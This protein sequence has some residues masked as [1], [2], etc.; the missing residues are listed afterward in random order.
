M[1]K[2][3]LPL[4]FLTVVAA[5][6]I[7]KAQTTQDPL[8]I[9]RDSLSA[10][11]A[12]IHHMR[13]GNILIS[14]RLDSLVRQLRLKD[15]GPQADDH[16]QALLKEADMLAERDREAGESMMKKFQSGVR[17]QQGLNPNISLGGDFFAAVST[18]DNSFISEP[19]DVYHGNNGFHLREVELALEAPLDP[20]TR[21]KSFFSINEG[22]IAIEEAYLEWLNLPLNMNL[23]A[24]IFYP[25]FGPLNRYHDHA[26]PQFDRPIAL[27]NLFSNKGL[28]GAGV[29]TS[30]MLPRLIFSDATTLDL[31]AIKSPDTGNSFSFSNKGMLFIGQFKNFYDITQNTYFEFRISGVAG[32]NPAGSTRNSFIGSLGLSYKWVP[33]GREKYKTFDWKTELLYSYRETPGGE[34]VT[35]GFY[36]TI[37]N[38]LNYRFWLGARVGYSELPFDHDRFLWDYTLNLDFWQSEFVFLRLQYQYNRREIYYSTTGRIPGDNTLLLQICWAM[39]PHKHEAY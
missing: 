26:L 8:R 22:G 2:K 9:L 5:V 29:S 30:F 37:Q 4:V 21:G 12:E 11:H 36:T 7:G 38:K 23:K 3:I 15:S 17:Q 27:V 35:K 10:L 13:A 6:N 19:G 34:T 1:S 31:S 32:R 14:N 39:G 18:S 28:T 16:L 25:E 24:G 33:I 20:F